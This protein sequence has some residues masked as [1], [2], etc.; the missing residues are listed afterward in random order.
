MLRYHGPGAAEPGTF[1]KCVVQLDE[2][3]GLPWD[4]K[5]FQNQLIVT[6]H[7]G[8]QRFSPKNPEAEAEP[9]A[10]VLMID[11]ESGAELC[12]IRSKLFDQPNMIA[13][14]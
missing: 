2:G 3:R 11:P 14:E 10:R 13:L 1:D 12:C 4:V 6:V 9:E 8:K 7:N 5:C